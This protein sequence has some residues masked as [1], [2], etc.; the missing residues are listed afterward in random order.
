[1]GNLLKGESLKW[2]NLLKGGLSKIGNLPKNG[3]ISKTGHL[4]KRKYFK[5]GIC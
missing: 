5:W 3:G 1:M 2:G 4:L